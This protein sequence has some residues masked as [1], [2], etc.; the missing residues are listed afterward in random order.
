M[1]KTLTINFND[2]SQKVF[3]FDGGNSLSEL[4]KLAGET[5]VGLKAEMNPDRGEKDILSF[6]IDGHGHPGPGTWNVTRNGAEFWPTVSE[7]EERPLNDGDEIVFT[8]KSDA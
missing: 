4:F 1:S 5:T 8:L 3:S 6:H 7:F 2:G